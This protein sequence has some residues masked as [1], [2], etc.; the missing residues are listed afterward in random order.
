MEDANSIYNVHYTEPENEYSS[1]SITLYNQ[2]NA[3]NARL[4]AAAPEMYGLL[5]EL[6]IHFQHGNSDHWKLNDEKIQ[7]IESLLA[8]ARGEAE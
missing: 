5:N 2:D 1:A 8:K 7:P 6:L 3:A 4:I